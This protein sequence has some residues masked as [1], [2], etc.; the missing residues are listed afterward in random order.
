M[1]CRESLA[2]NTQKLRAS[3]IMVSTNGE[4]SALSSQRAYPQYAGGTLDTRYQNV[5]DGP[6]G[7]LEPRFQ[8]GLCHDRRLLCF[9]T[10][11]RW[12]PVLK[13]DAAPN[14]EQGD[15][16]HIGD[17]H[18]A[19]CLCTTIKGPTAACQAPSRRS[20]GSDLFTLVS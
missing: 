20:C 11:V 14:D 17:A 4:L 6:A 9:L 16:Q 1:L 2:S 10:W 3:S 8:F 13:F 19:V 15:V 7:K 12:R 18:P 5:A